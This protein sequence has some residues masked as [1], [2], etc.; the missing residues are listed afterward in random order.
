MTWGH[1]TGEQPL[2]DFG[3]DAVYAFNVRKLR[4]RMEQRFR[5]AWPTAWKQT[6]EADPQGLE[7]VADSGSYAMRVPSV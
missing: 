1:K 3:Q 7:T 2:S 6:W 4:E 5:W